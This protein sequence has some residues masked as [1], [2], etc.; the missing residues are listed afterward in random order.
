[1]NERTAA[2]EN[3]KQVQFNWGTFNIPTLAAAAVLAGMLYN[4]GGRQERQ[5]ARIDALGAA[6]TALDVQR[7]A[8]SAEINKVLEALSV[9]IQPID[10]LVYRLTSL[11]TMVTSNNVAVN[12]RI[13]RQSDTLSALRDGM[14]KLS[15]QLEV[16]TQRLPEKKAE[17]SGT[18]RELMAIR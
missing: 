14:A 9:K 3:N 17:I 5:D 2:M 7:A 10:N 12:A 8:R 15:T 4:A 1:M 11:E 16:I 18:P 13:D 6:D